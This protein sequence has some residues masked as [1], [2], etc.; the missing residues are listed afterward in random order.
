[1]K[2]KN[3]RRSGPGKFLTKKSVSTLKSNR[4][5]GPNNDTHHL[6]ALNEPPESLRQ[7]REELAHHSDITEYAQ[8][9]VSFGDC[10]GRIALKLDIALDGE[11][12][13]EPLCEVLVTALRNRR[14]HPTQPHLR[15]MGLM[16]VELVE[17][18]DGISLEKRDRNVETKIPDGSVVVEK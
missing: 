14:L 3:S 11:Y 12:D 13:C 17:K 1:M 10:L 5:G 15:A 9:G 4:S 2:K 7:L 16:D 18:E 8:H 6:I